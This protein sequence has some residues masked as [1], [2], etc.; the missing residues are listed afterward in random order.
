MNPT[1]PVDPLRPLKPRLAVRRG[2]WVVVGRIPMD[3]E[4]WV[5][6]W[7]RAME[8]AFTQNRGA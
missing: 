2:R 4:R 8:W 1:L 7:R 6:E 3:D 5:R